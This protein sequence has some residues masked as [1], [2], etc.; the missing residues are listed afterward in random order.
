[1]K[2]IVKKH[3]LAIRWFHWINFPVLGVMIWSGLLVY[4]ANDVYKIGFGDKTLIKFFPQSFYDAFHIPFHLAEGID[5]S[6]ASGLFRA[7]DLL[8]V[9]LCAG[10]GPAED[11]SVFVPDR[12]ASGVGTEHFTVNVSCALAVPADCFP[13]PVRHA[14]GGCPGRN[15]QQGEYHNNGYLFHG[16]FP[17]FP[18]AQQLI[19]VLRSKRSRVPAGSP[20][21][22]R[23]GIPRL[24]LG[25]KAL[26]RDREK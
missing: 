11:L 17:S 25:G 8:Q 3:P 10:A 26:P 1:M 4:W 6:A 14:I 13:K 7:P 16:H 2:K 5:S 22:P 20:A 21:I 12:A 18:T 9:V 19:T 15:K 24:P 23:L